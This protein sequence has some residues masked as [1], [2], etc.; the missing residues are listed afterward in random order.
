MFKENKSSEK[1]KCRFLPEGNSKT[2]LNGS[3]HMGSEQCD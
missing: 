2:G 3:L 1:I